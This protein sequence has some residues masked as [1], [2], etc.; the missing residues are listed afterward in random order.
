M[1]AGDRA[2]GGERGRLDDAGEAGA[3]G[4]LGGAVAAVVAD[5]VDVDGEL[6]GRVDGDV[7]VD[8]LAG[9]DGAGGGEALDLAVHVVGGAGAA[10]AAGAGDRGRRSRRRVHVPGDDLAGVVEVVLA[11]AEPGQRAL[12]EGVGHRVRE[13][14]RLPAPDLLRTP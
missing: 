3:G 5:A 2:V 7:E 10:G 12:A 6:L 1:V 11:A 13:R 14:T 9:G 8:G 4:D